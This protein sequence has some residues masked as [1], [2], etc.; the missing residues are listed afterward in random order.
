M[1]KLM[2]TASLSCPCFHPGPWPSMACALSST[3]HSFRFRAMSLI[4][5]MSA[6]R[7]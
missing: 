4:A 2:Q 5:F 3:T 1:M 6:Q 7:P